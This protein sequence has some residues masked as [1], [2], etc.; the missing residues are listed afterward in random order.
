MLPEG[1][2]G[3]RKARRG[4]VWTQAHLPVRLGLVHS[5][6]C[7]PHFKKKAME[8]LF[9]RVERKMVKSLIMVHPCT[10]IQNTPAS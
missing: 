6:V 3:F 4:C 5:A 7:V 10:F 1:C 2:E 9:P 8:L